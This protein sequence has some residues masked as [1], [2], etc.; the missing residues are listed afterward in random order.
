MGQSDFGRL[1]AEGGFFF[2]LGGGG[3]RA[4]PAAPPVDDSAERDA[5]RARTATS[6]RGMHRP[7]KSWPL[8]FS[9]CVESQVTERR[10][11]DCCVIFHVLRSQTRC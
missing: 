8:V 5:V 2:F 3:L 4:V 7:E 11:L 10:K 6:L 1:S 9:I